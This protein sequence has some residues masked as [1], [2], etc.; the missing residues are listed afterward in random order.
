MYVYVSIVVL[1]NFDINKAEKEKQ[2]QYITCLL[3]FALKNKHLKSLVVK[4][5]INQDVLT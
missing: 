2:L 4:H 1:L 5:C 3:I